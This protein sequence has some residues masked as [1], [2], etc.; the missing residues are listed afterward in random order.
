VSGYGIGDIETVAWLVV[1]LGVIPWVGFGIAQLNSLAV[2]R[3]VGWSWV[4]VAV[5]F[6]ERMSVNEP[7]GTR[8]L[9]VIGALLWSMKAVVYF[10]S[11]QQGRY[12]LKW[13]QWLGFCVGWVGMRAEAFKQ[14]PALP[15]ADWKGYIQRGILRV[16]AGSAL[17]A[18][19]WIVAHGVFNPGGLT[20]AEEIETS[21]RWAATG[22]LLPGLSLVVHFGLFNI[23]T[24]VWRYFGARCTSLFRAPLLSK[25]L[26][27]FWGR[28]WNLAFSEMTALA[29]F[30]PLKQLPGRPEQVTMLATI[31][32]F[33]FSGL[34]HELAISVPVGAGYGLP[35]LYFA[36]HGVGIVLE[37]RLAFL[38]SPWLGR[39]WTMAWVL[40]PLPILFHRPFLEGCVWPIIGI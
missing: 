19:A 16:L 22:L 13:W 28:R 4:A 2:A 40:L 34:L 12:E 1:F 3:F 29:V 23:L 39:I 31:A 11:R 6:V 25:S 26:T 18:A 9:L 5:L 27:E 37:K 30:R 7:S 36:I 10:E 17:V 21:R 35:L 24:G 33:L 15:L 38:S 14:V 32:G 8:M 20:Q